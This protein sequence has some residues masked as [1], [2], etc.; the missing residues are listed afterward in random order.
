MTTCGS[1]DW[2]CEALGRLGIEGFPARTIE[3]LLSQPFKILLILLLTM[4]LSR[5]GARLARH[6]VES[7]GTRSPFGER[8]A[9]AAQ[10]SVTLGGVVASSVRVVV[11]TFGTLA[12]LDEVGLNLAPLL[13]GASIV[14]VAVGFGAQSIVKDFLS[15]FFILVEDQYGIGDSITIAEV[16]GTV[17]EVNLRLTQLRGADGTVWFVPNGEIRKVGNSTK[18]AASKPPPA[19]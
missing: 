13:A 6:S 3:W 14:G 11:W 19:P 5:V 7:V 17:E 9:R 18:R 2:V 4:V 12:V 1:D 8:S 10:R 15:G 16:T